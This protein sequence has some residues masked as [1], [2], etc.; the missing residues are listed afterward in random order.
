MAKKKTASKPKRPSP[1]KKADPLME[2][3]QKTLIKMSKAEL[4][5][6]VM[7]MARN[8]ADIRDQFVNQLDV[9]IPLPPASKTNLKAIVAAT[10]EA[11]AKATWFDP[12]QMNHNFDID[13]R[14]YESVQ[15]H[16]KQLVAAK[17]FE[18]A[19]ELAIE[20]MDKGSYQ[21][22]MSDEGMMLDEVQDSLRPVT[23]GL[24]QSGLPEAKVE[25]WLESIC[26]ADRCGFV[27][28]DDLMR[29]KKGR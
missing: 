6:T 5:D 10:R 17:H 3:L 8:E 1:K 9:Q 21:I 22:E 24:S 4:I 7:R 19:V 23:M 14:A 26:A 2:Q 12:R 13:Y 27:W 15:R 29:P 11:I 25:Q 18:P 28:S 20:L 16:L